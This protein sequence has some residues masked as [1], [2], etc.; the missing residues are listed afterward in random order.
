MGIIAAKKNVPKLALS[1]FSP[2]CRPYKGEIYIFKIFSL[3]K[4]I[5]VFLSSDFFQW[6][7]SLI[8]QAQPWGGGPHQQGFQI[9]TQP[10]RRTSIKRQCQP[11]RV[12]GPHG[13]ATGP[14]GRTPAGP[15][16]G[17]R[18]C[19]SLWRQVRS[20]RNRSL[21]IQKCAVSIF[22]KKR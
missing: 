14:P 20:E 4:K 11:Q 2:S 18:P 22:F 1:Y 6:K 9:P 3:R 16:G 8:L 15:A 10:W 17:W 21:N 12:R 7:I 19:A 13:F 5:C